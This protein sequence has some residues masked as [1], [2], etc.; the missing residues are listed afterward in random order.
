[1]H[2]KPMTSMSRAGGENSSEDDDEEE[3]LQDGRAARPRKRTKL[4]KDVLAEQVRP[5]LL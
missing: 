2:V 3:D 4:L 5:W 1:M